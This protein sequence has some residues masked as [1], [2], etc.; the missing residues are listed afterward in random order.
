MNN[1]NEQTVWRVCTITIFWNAV[2]SVFKLFAGIFA[3]SGAMFSDAVHSLSDVFTTIV[4]IIGTKAAN[5]A[6]DKEHP[7]GH[8]RMEC[9]TAIMLSMILGCTGLG[10]GYSG[11][12][13]ILSSDK[14]SLPI[15]GLLAL[16]AAIISIFIKECMYWYTRAAAKKIDSGALLADAWHHRSDSLSSLGSLLGILGA[17]LGFPVLDPIASVIICCFI[18]ISA[19]QIFMDSIRKM[20]DNACDEKTLDGICMVI[21]NQKGVLGIDQVKTRLFGNRIYVDV[22][23]QAD[24]A[25]PLSEAHSIAHMVNDAIAAEFPEVKHCM[26]H[27]NPTFDICDDDYEV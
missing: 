11:L 14:D 20:I 22:E 2:L 27:V 18:F 17:R 24:G 5:K 19:C 9:V 21:T 7:Y 6:S 15:P 1:T 25:Q 8:E 13:K 16:A 3:H 4:V 26:V 12:L 10:I 23:I